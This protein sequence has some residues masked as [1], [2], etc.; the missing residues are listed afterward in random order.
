MNEHKKTLFSI[1]FIVMASALFVLCAIIFNK[2]Y[3]GKTVKDDDV[4]GIKYEGVEK[5]YKKDSSYRVRTTYSGFSQKALIEASFSGDM[6]LGVEVLSAEGIPSYYD[7]RALGKKY[8]AQFK[9]RISTDPKLDSADRDFIEI[10]PLS[11]NDKAGI[12]LLNCV[13]RCCR[14]Y[15][16]TILKEGGDS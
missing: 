10:E 4:P 13:D 6:L 8:L 3:A 9:G 2:S 11:E 14:A 12:E 15:Y 1:F 16:E 5:I 7:D